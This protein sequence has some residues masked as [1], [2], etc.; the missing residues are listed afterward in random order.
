MSQLKKLRRG[1]RAGR[2]VAS[3]TMLDS[4]DDPVRL[5]RQL[6]AFADDCVPFKFDRP[7]DDLPDT[8][9]GGRLISPLPY[10]RVWLEDRDIALLVAD[11][12]DGVSRH[13]FMFMLVDGEAPRLGS[14]AVLNWP[15][16]IVGAPTTELMHCVVMTPVER[17]PLE[18]VVQL[19]AVSV[20]RALDAI[21][22][23]TTVIDAPPIRSPGKARGKALRTLYRTVRIGARTVA[24]GNDLGGTHASPCAHMRRGHWRQS[25]KT[26][27][28][29]WVK[30]TVV[31]AWKEGPE[32][33]YS[34]T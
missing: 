5:V 13:I 16:G 23:E 27:R 22:A 7:I 17:L 6:E 29:W 21:N 4:L 24:A 12:D 14:A 10:Q 20:R 28:R 30:P 8:P 31:C 19:L 32:Q 2:I 15:E 9:V 25:H 33:E 11:S 3:E 26:G 34:V 18:E 1:L